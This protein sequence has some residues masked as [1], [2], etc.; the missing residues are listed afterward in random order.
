LLQDKC[1]TIQYVI[2]WH[3]LK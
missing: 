3:G 2:S 1:F